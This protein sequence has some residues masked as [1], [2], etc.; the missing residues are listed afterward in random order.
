M[1]YLVRNLRFI[2]GDLI[3]RKNEIWRVYLI[4]LQ[5]TNILM[6][7]DISSQQIHNLETLIEQHNSMYVYKSF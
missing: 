4:L 2:I 6:M 3:P 1:Y 7:P 5:I